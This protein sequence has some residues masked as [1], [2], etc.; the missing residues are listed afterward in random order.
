[1]Q[2]FN[3]NNIITESEMSDE[4]RLLKSFLHFAKSEGFNRVDEILNQRNYEELARRF[5]MQTG[6][7]V[8]GVMEE[9]RIDEVNL[10]KMA[11][12]LGLI[13]TL[14]TAGQVA[15]YDYNDFNKMGFS[16]PESEKLEQM[17]DTD[18]QKAA[19]IVNNQIKQMR[20]IDGQGAKKVYGGDTLLFPQTSADTIKTD[21]P[22][23]IGRYIGTDADPQ[24]KGGTR[25]NR[26]P[27]TNL[28]P[29]ERSMGSGDP[30]KL[31][32][33]ALILNDVIRADRRLSQNID[34]IYYSTT[35]N[36]I[37]VIPN[38]PDYGRQAGVKIDSKLGKSILDNVARR[39]VTPIITRQITKIGL[40]GI[41]MD[42]VLIVDRPGRAP[43]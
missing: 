17:A 14:F 41:D 25:A 12:T 34:R 26:D 11:A 3:F 8:G 1:M 18:P 20:Q 21:K 28:D 31:R 2:L 42:N 38:F 37:V 33:G 27:F 32:N 23:N 16:K 6:Q 7:D 15:A 39:M 40:P 36:K 13:T 19:D 5:R 30:E 24:Q 9:G 10:R 43:R 22:T 29:D 4:E 35:L